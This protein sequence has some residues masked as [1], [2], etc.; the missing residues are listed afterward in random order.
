MH[1]RLEPYNPELTGVEDMAAALI[2][3]QKREKRPDDLH[4]YNEKVTAALEQVLF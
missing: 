3:A 1:K 4:E 2:A